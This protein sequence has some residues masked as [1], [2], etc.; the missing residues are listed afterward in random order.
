MLAISSPDTDADNKLIDI[1]GLYWLGKAAAIFASLQRLQKFISVLP[2]PYLS[3]LNS[4]VPLSMEVEDKE[5][6]RL[7]FF[8]ASEEAFDDITAQQ[9]Q[10]WIRDFISGSLQLKM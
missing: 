1:A 3:F 4:G 10:G 2:L 5:H 9:C 8:Q 6:E 7:H